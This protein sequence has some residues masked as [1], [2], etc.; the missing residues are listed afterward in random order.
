VIMIPQ[1]VRG[2]REKKGE[3][4]VCCLFVCLFT[5]TNTSSVKIRLAAVV[6]V[7]DI[8][9]LV[10]AAALA[11]LAHLLPRLLTLAGLLLLLIAGLL[12]LAGL[13][14]LLL[15][16]LLALTGLLLLLLAL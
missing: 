4:L 7:G 12:A 5:R 10:V 9:A 2:R 15:A 14:L 16:V 1:K 13:F 6:V 3:S 11:L 8:A